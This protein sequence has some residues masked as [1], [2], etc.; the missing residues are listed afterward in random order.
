MKRVRQPRENAYRT[1]VSSRS[2]SRRALCCADRCRRAASLPSPGGDAGRL[3]GAPEQPRGRARR[4]SR[5]TASWPRRSAISSSAMPSPSSRHTARS[6]C[7]EGLAPARKNSCVR[8]SAGEN[9]SVQRD[10]LPVAPGAARLLVVGLDAARQLGVGDEPDVRLVHAH[11]ERVG[12]RRSR[13]PGRRGSRP[14]RA[15]AP[16]PTSPAW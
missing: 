15:C 3:G 8:T 1:I 16:R 2:R 7:A 4:S 9:S 11:A 5:S 13:R 10:G 14:A 6:T 12:R